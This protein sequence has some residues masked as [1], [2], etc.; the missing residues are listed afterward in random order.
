MSQEN[1]RPENLFKIGDIARLFHISVST[2]RHYEELGLVMPEYIHPETGYRY[3]SINQFEVLSTLRYLRVLDMPLGKISSFLENRSLDTIERMLKEQKAA[4]D[5]KQREL[6]RVGRKLDR[7]LAQITEARTSVFGEVQ[8]IESEPGRIVWLRYEFYASAGS[9]PEAPLMRVDFNRKDPI[10]F[11]GK[12]GAGISL[13][14]LLLKEFERYD[15]IFLLLADEDEY[16]GE[17]EILPAQ[18]CLSVRFHG[19]HKDAAP[20]YRLLTEKM[21]ESGWEPAGFSREVTIIDQGLS[22]DPA[23]Y[24]TEI[25][26]PVREK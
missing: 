11:L 2:L 12:V 9:L 21:E 20:Y 1:I 10:V 4:V 15:T 6:V 26:I 8:E 18:R 17:Y 5:E 23:D 16:E 19:H 13:E 25:Q 7:R 3:Y 22:S 14:H 24:V